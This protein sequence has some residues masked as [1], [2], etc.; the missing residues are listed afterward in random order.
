M[1][2][3]KSPGTDGLTAEFYK[4]FWSDIKIL[5][6]NSLNFSLSSGKFSIEQ[7][8]GILSLLPKKNKDRLYLKKME[9]HNSSQRRL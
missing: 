3:G 5:L 6:L 7:R 1:K 2:N 9:A 4:F 8:R